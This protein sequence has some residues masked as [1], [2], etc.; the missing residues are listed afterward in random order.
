M[1]GRGGVHALV[2]FAK[3]AGEAPQIRRAPDYAAKLLDPHLPGSLAHFYDTMSFDQFRLRGTVLSKRYSSAQSASAYLADDPSKE[4]GNYGRFVS[5]VLRQ[6]D[7]DVDFTQFDNDGPDGVPNSGDDD[8][9]VDYIFVNVLSTPRG[10]LVGG[11]TGIAGLGFDTAYRCQDLGINGEP[12]RIPLGEAYGSILREGIFAQT[13][14]VM[15]HEFGHALELP[16]LYDLAYTGPE[17]DSAGIGRWGLMGLGALGWQGDDGPNPFCA[18]SRQQLGWLGRANER[19][20]DV[21]ADANGLVLD[22]LDAGGTVYR[23]PL[24]GEAN[25]GGLSFWE[26]YLLL[27]Q[28]TRQSTHYHRHLPGEGVLVWQVQPQL[29][30]NGEEDRKVL[31]L[32]CA[33]GLYKDAGYP[34]GQQEDGRFG[35]DNLDFWAHDSA[36]AQAHAGNQGDATDPFDGVRFRRFELGTNPSNHVRDLVAGASSGVELTLQRQGEGMQLDVRQPRW[37]GTINGATTWYNTVLVEGDV[38]VAPQAELTIMPGTQVLFA[39]ADRLH[40]GQDPSRCELGIEGDLQL[41]A[42]PL[43]GKTRFASKSAG[44]S[45]YGIALEPSASSELDIAQDGFEVHDSERG[46]FFSRAPAVV[47]EGGV[48]RE[49]ALLDHFGAQTVGNGDGQLNPGEIFQVQVALDNWTLA[50]QVYAVTLDWDSALVT[51]AWTLSTAAAAPQL[52]GGELHLSIGEGGVVQLPS[53]YLSAAAEAGQ[54][55]DFEVSLKGESKSW[56]EVISFTVVGR[57]GGAEVAFAAS[58]QGAIVAEVGRDAAVEVVVEDEVVRV[59]LMVRS[60][61][62]LKPVAQLEMTRVA[63]GVGGRTFAVA[64][65]PT[66]PGWYKSFARLHRRDGS[67]VLSEVSLDIWALRS[68]QHVPTLAVLGAPYT[69]EQKEGIRRQLDQL[70]RASG[71]TVLVVDRG[72]VGDEVFAKLLLRYL[73]VGNELLWIGDVRFKLEAGLRAIVEQGGHIGLIAN[74]FGLSAQFRKEVLHI[75]RALARGRQQLSSLGFG[76]TGLFFEHPVE[77]DASYKW[78]ELQAPA[79][80]VMVDEEGR[81][82]ALRVN[83]GVSRLFYLSFDLQGVGQSA[84]RNVLKAALDFFRRDTAGEAG[85]QVL[86]KMAG[87]DQV[88]VRAEVAG[89]P[90]AADLLVRSYPRLELLAELPMERAAETGGKQVFET[91]FQPAGLGQYQLALRLHDEAGEV[92]L[93]DAT[94]RGVGIATQRQVLVLL[95]QQYEE[96]QKAQL[97]T[98]IGETLERMGLSADFIDLLDVEGEFLEDALRHYTDPGK[99]VIW[100]GESAEGNSIDVF[101]RFLAGGGRAF[102]ISR[103]F[104]TGAGSDFRTRFL[105]IGS[106][107]TYSPRGLGIRSLQLEENIELFAAH[108]ALQ[109]L[110]PAEPILLNQQH[111]PAGLQVKTDSFRIVYFPFDLGAVAVQVYQP[112]VEAGMRFLLQEEAPPLVIDMPDHS[113]EDQM[114]TAEVGEEAR[115]RVRLEGEVGGGQLQVR[116]LTQRQLLE[117]LPLRQVVGAESMYEADFRLADAGQYQLVPQFYNDAHEPLHSSVHLNVLSVPRRQAVLVLL[118]PQYADGD[119]AALR[120]ALDGVLQARG[121]AAAY[122]RLFG[123]DPLVYETVLERHLQ[124]GQLVLWIGEEMDPAVQAVFARF[125]RG[126]GNFFFI[127]H[128]LALA[129]GEEALHKD[130]FHIDRVKLAKKQRIRAVE[131]ERELAFRAAHILLEPLPPA[132]PVLL[133]EQNKTAGLRV[134]TGL[135]RLVYFPFKLRDV[136]PDVYGVL[137]QEGLDFLLRQE[138]VPA[139]IEV[140]DHALVGQTL[141]LDMDEGV[142]VRVQVEQEVGYGQLQVRSLPQRQL[143]ATLPLRQDGE[144][145]VHEAFFQPPGAGKYQLEPQFY[146]AAGTPL[147]SVARLR[148]IG[149]PVRPPV[150]VFLGEDYDVDASKRIAALFDQSFATLG[151]EAIYLDQPD[152]DP[153]LY[154]A[155]LTHYLDP[156]DVVIWAGGDLD[157]AMSAV[158]QGFAKRGGNLF[159]ISNNPGLVPA[160]F[161]EQVFHISKIVS[162]SARQLRPIVSTLPSSFRARHMSLTIHSPALPILLN[163]KHKVAGLQVDEGTSRLVYLPFN[164]PL[165]DWAAFQSIFESALFFLRQQVLVQLEMSGSPSVD[166]VIPFGEDTAMRVEVRGKV[167]EAKLLVYSLPRYELVDTLPMQRLEIE[168]GV[169]VFETAMRPPGVGFFQVLLQLQVPGGA[170]VQGSA[171]LLNSTMAGNKPVLV[172]VDQS[173]DAE[174]WQ[175]LRATFETALGEL[176][177]AFDMVELSV[178]T[179]GLQESFLDHFKDEGDIVVWLGNSMDQNTQAIFRNYLE[180]G[181]NLLAASLNFS[182]SPGIGDFLGELLHVPAV[183]EIAKT[184]LHF[185]PDGRGA[186]LMPPVHRVLEVGGAAEP[187]L[188]GEGG[189]IAGVRVADV[190]KVVYLPFDLKDLDGEAQRVLLESQLAFLQPEKAARLKLLLGAEPQRQIMRLQAWSPQVTVANGGNGDSPPFRIAYQVVRDGQVIASAGRDEISLQGQ[191]RRVIE[192]PAWMPP[193]EGGYDVFFG[194]SAEAGDDLVYQPGQHFDFAQAPPPFVEAELPGDIDKG[195]GAGFFDYDGDGDLDLLLVRRQAP[196]RLLRNDGSDFSEQTQAAGLRSTAIDRGL[197]FGDYDGDGDLDLYLV[198]EAANLFFNN[199]GDGTFV[200]VTDQVTGTSLADEGSG[201]SAAF[202]D[203]DGD[204]DLDLYVV[205]AGGGNPFYSNEGGRYSERA[206]AVGLADEGNGRGLALGDFDGDGAVDV[207]VANTAGGSRLLRSEGLGFVAVEEEFGLNFNG[208]EVAAAFGDVDGDGGVDLL[209]ANESGKNQLFRNAGDHFEELTEAALDLGQRSVGATWWDY[210]NDGDL[211]VALTALNVSWGGDEVYHNRGDGLMPVGSLL[212]LADSTVGRGMSAADIDG[213]G[214][215]D[216]LVA[217]AQRSRLYRNQSAASHWLEVEL[218]GL[219]LNRY[220]LGAKVEVV[221]G[222]RRWV[223]EMQSGYGYASQVQPRLHFGL[224]AATRVDTLRVV[225]PDGWEQALTQV[226]AGQRLKVEYVDAPTKVLSVVAALPGEMRLWQ[227]YPNPFNSSTMIRFAVP[228]AGQVELAIFNLTGQRLAVREVEA[229]QAGV[230]EV[231]WHGRDDNGRAVASGLY[232]Y[233]L[234]VGT[235]TER[236]KLLLLR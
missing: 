44:E 102:F 39:G 134:D 163:E 135:F 40:S 146:S 26:D 65:R 3:F 75:Q 120:A 213:D 128:Q 203:G 160:D 159:F 227:N 218:E 151:L 60:M 90:A 41:A 143:L 99:A 38:R 222:G 156:G 15:A 89:A 35:A 169:T 188:F 111:R 27:E 216:L 186:P 191:S 131:P 10:F 228:Q 208:G 94:L 204:G 234:Q 53:L 112:L 95:G 196:S 76:R 88:R 32:I 225:W 74:R 130:I 181:G 211:D 57:D 176:G 58:E 206:A 195:N 142:R 179:E 24:N 193:L 33:D 6:V 106:A 154:E 117:V 187:V 175:R 231:H 137:L 49:Y 100:L 235:Q 148:V 171:A 85:L 34:L 205:N 167:E 161:R 50:P 215:L 119:Q 226:A 199:E 209:V 236:R 45:W 73:H 18:W 144:A 132:E 107:S 80:A 48:Q 51:P 21:A 115:V 201:R 71:R 147:Y 125:V 17:D 153:T 207:F 183:G 87:S 230:Y 116:S 164:L 104:H 189:Q 72:E 124:E 23:I 61:P 42:R 172:M 16:D 220:G 25:R 158:F 13:V 113:V 232:I 2:I 173:Y 9:R 178:K 182:K 190:Y 36:Y 157:V 19:L 69:Q 63:A 200:E 165:N 82:A 177:M 46:I 110:A 79:Q 68:S 202:F 52:L 96:G 59:D 93:S 56:R 152:N 219:S 78:L 86:D 141:V 224:G 184:A 166:G 37:A 133:N 29:V 118:G 194:M 8:G 155:L 64:Y 136:N 77:L 30:G 109:P 7:A 168:A 212:A 81:V 55:I 126:G 54:S 114:F 98:A 105:H 101:T 70:A 1:R 12:I 66:E 229:L 122:L 214:T 197:A 170:I 150:L 83:S 43:F 5:E 198:S 11:A 233:Q 4:A 174:Q 139:T 162:T 47:G 84:T 127:S 14:G 210:D 31:D 180:G 140:P 123:Q 145:Q 20:V 149:V 121:L 62:Q 22:A 223:R 28:V 217:D 92:L 91:A 138:A 185:Q 129:P 67:V 97:R 103:Q 108:L 192:F 221:A